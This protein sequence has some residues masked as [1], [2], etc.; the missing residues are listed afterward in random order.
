[1]MKNIGQ[2]LYMTFFVNAN[3]DILRNVP[4]SGSQ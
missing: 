1:M 4:Y 2:N 3:E